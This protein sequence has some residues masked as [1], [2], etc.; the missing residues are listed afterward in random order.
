VA[1]FLAFLRRPMAAW[2][3]PP[4]ALMQSLLPGS[5]GNLRDD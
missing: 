2:R 4:K 3:Q 5:S 1:L